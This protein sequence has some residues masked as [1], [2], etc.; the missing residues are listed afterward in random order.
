MES[1]IKDL[2]YGYRTLLRNPG[3]TA[4]AVLSLAL[5]IGANTAIFSFINTVLL[6]TLPVRAPEQLVVFG[7]GKGRGI[8]GGPPDG[9][10]DLFSWEQYKTFRKQ[11][12]SFEDILA[13]NSLPARLYL[14]LSGE[15]ATGL[16]ESAQANLVSGNYF[17]VRREAGGGAP[18]QPGNGRLARRKS[19]YGA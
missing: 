8:Y 16:P 15:N 4:V 10:M 7:Q 18:F 14:T 3:F 13:V 5:G 11:N 9:S 19:L 17:E 12:K 6:K 2:R 1:L